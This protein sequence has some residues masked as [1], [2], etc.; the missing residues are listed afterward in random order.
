[1]PWRNTTIMDEKYFF[2]NE[3]RAHNFTMTELC[4]Q[5]GISR[6]LGYKYVKRFK[7]MGI[8]G[9]EELSRK[10]KSSPSKTNPKA[11]KTI[12]TI[13]T[14]HSRYGAKKI[15]TIIE[16]DFPHIECPSQT[17][18]NTILNKEGLIP[19][20]KTNRHIYPCNQKFNP[21][22]P[23]DI[24]SI[25][26]KGKMRLF[27]PVY[28]YP[29]TLSDSFSRFILAADALE[30]PTSQA[31]QD[32]L[33]RVFMEF[34]LPT[35]IH[36][37]NGVPFACSTSLARLSS[38]SVWLI[39]HDISPLYS[40]PGKPGQNGRHERMHKELKAYSASPLPHSHRELQ[41]R[42]TSFLHEYNEYRP[43]EALG[44]KPPA[45]IYTKSDRI[46]KTKIEPWVYPGSFEVKR[47]LRN[48]AI[49]WGNE[50]WI[51]VATPLIGKDIALEEIGNGI[52]RVFFRFKLLGYLD[53]KRLRIQDVQGRL[54]RH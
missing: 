29:L 6:T 10:P 44:N 31:T 25:D 16:R 18:I 12:I 28:S 11:V 13:R 20:R 37:D 38:L 54:K 45:S 40:D 19:E 52:F 17:T 5:F 15:K 47:V 21:S 26:F 33:T 7:E 49:R 35:Y 24:W 3:Y 36:S 14:K 4:K 22:L 43:H 30:N 2:I 50:N 27:D 41:K 1:M 8:K 51:M 53:V 9:L 42:L 39:E 32:V 34:G 46:Y 23:N 48:G